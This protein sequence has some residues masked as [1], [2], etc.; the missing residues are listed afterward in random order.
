M[1]SGVFYD[2]PR[3]YTGIAET[4]A[5]FIGCLLTKRKVSD[6]R[7]GV[8]SAA[9][10]VVLCTFLELTRDVPIFLWLPCMVVAFL[11]MYLYS[12]L[13]IKEGCRNL[14]FYT[15]H[16]FLAAELVASLEWQLSLF[17]EYELGLGAASRTVTLIVVYGISYYTIYSLEKTVLSGDRFFTEYSRRD[18]FI[19]AIIVAFTFAVSNISFILPMDF[20]TAGTPQE[21]FTLRTVVDLGGLAILYAFRSRIHEL[22]RAKELQTMNTVL[23]S[24]YDGYRNYQEMIDLINFKYHD[25]KNQLIGLAA[26]EDPKRRG[27]LIA[28]MQKELEKYRPEHKTGNKV[29]DTLIAGKTT[30]LRNSDIKFTCVA[31]GTI[32]SDIHVTDICS[33]FGNALDNAIEYEAQVADPEKRIIH[34]TLTARQGYIFIEVSNY[35]EE[36]LKMKN[37]MPQTTKHD[38]KLH[39]YGVKSMLYTAQK[40]GGTLTYTQHDHILEL[41]VLIPQKSLR[42]C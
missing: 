23:Q 35:I 40:Y 1:D 38:K 27:E 3:I 39:G 12:A 5:V 15:F 28:T 30:R 33:I 4:L 6:G 11:L 31:D 29:L 20:F 10:L 16:G 7:F 8:I 13:V 34:M 18:V 2:I 19:A 42:I 32:L 9:F 36:E 26:E 24:Q 25:L 17:F 14:I 41:K 22:Q 21:N 37:G